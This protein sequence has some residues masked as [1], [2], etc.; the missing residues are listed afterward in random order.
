M[1]HSKKMKRKIDKLLIGILSKDHKRVKQFLYNIF[2]ENRKS[3]R[4]T[5]R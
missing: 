3:A 4:L 1:N 5:V 2:I